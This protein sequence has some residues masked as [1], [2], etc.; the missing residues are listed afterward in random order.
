LNIGDWVIISFIHGDPEKACAI[1]KAQK[2]GK[3]SVARYRSIRSNWIF[4]NKTRVTKSIKKFKF[5]TKKTLLRE[6]EGSVLRMPLFGRKMPVV[7]KL[8]EDLGDKKLEKQARAA[9]ILSEVGEPAIPVLIEA[10]GDTNKQATAGVT[11]KDMVKHG[12]ARPMAIIPYLIKTLGDKKK[13]A[14]AATLLKSREFSH[15][16]IEPL[17]RASSE[18]F[19]SSDKKI[20]AYLA[21]KGISEDVF[22]EQDQNTRQAAS[23]ALKQIKARGLP[24]GFPET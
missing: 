7:Q 9:K 5:F 11:L 19:A 16:A 8:I 17:V 18:F 24:K 3:N 12:H 13:Q 1:L 4:V 23:N 14:M 2:H 20:Y 15:A 21:L 10:L 6:E 22:Q